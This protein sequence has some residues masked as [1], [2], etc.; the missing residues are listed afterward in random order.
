VDYLKTHRNF[1][2]NHTHETFHATASV[3]ILLDYLE[4]QLSLVPKVARRLALAIGGHHGTFPA[5][6]EWSQLSNTPRL[7]QRHW[8]E[9]Q[10]ELLTVL[11]RLLSLPHD[12]LPQAGDGEDQSY[13]MILAGLTSV[14]DWIGSNRASFPPCP[15][16][17]WLVDGQ[18][19]SHLVAQYF[20]GAD[21]RA[22]LALAQVGWHGRGQ[23]PQARKTFSDLF[24][25]LQLGS[26]R[27]LQEKA[28]ALAATLDGPALV[29]I[30]A[31]M[32]EGKTE[33]ALCLADAWDRRR[34]QGFYVALPTMAT[35]NGM[36]GRVENFLA[37]NYPGRQQLHLLHGRSL[38]SEAYERL[39]ANA[40]DPTLDVEVYDDDKHPGAVVAD[41]WFAKDKKQG[42]LAPFAVG[43]VDQALL[44]VLQTKHMFVRLFGLA[45]KVVILDEVHAYDTY[46]TTLLER[47]LEWLAALGTPS[48]CCR[49][50]CRA[51]SGSPCCG[52]TADLPLRFRKGRLTPVSPSPSPAKH[53]S[54]SS[55][56]RLRPK[57]RFISSGTMLTWAAWRRT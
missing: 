25:H 47:L 45:G 35:S 16:A 11:A 6:S 29:L 26:V 55:T 8:P 28:D 46:M 31:P 15:P 32:G 41:E 56:S 48:S 34:W 5:A 51:P 17:N 40:Q 14:A 38:L 4:Q 10:R 20:A 9:C 18:E 3:P 44:A 50:P 24:A 33:A 49:R 27:P 42:L 1:D 13:L 21:E 30:E 2:F 57:R 19:A 54:G 39:R 22:A 52:L 23:T 53:R 12:Q 36:F 43:T 37:A 7:G